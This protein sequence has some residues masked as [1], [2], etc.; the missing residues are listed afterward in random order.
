MVVKVKEPIAPEF[1]LM[2]EGQILFTYL[3]L[4]AAHELGAELLKRGVDR[5]RVRDHRDRPTASC[6]CS[7]R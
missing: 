4:A 5:R 1:A 2:R 7:R 6:R 3:H